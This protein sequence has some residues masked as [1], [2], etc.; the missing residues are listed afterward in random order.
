MFWPDMH[1]KDN[2][3]SAIKIIHV[4][5]SCRDFL[6]NQINQPPFSL[7]NIYH[8]SEGGEQRHYCLINRNSKG[9]AEFQWCFKVLLKD[10]PGEV[11]NGE[12][13]RTGI[14]GLLKGTGLTLWPFRLKQDNRCSILSLQ[15]QDRKGGSNYSLFNRP[16]IRH[17]L[18]SKLHNK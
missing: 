3:Q 6:Y 1:T 5:Q 12:D 4:M 15:H 17:S 16:W 2:M 7:Q 18:A 13:R 11:K 10:R 14:Y 8:D 9:R